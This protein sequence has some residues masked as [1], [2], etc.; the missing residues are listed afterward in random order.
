MEHKLLIWMMRNSTEK[1]HSLAFIVITLLVATVL[2]GALRV[3]VT[4]QTEIHKPVRADAREYLTYAYN[5]KHHGIYSRTFAEADSPPDAVRSPGYPIFLLPFTNG[6]PT[7]KSVKQITYTQAIIGA[8]VVSLSLMVFLKMMTPSFAIIAT[9]LTVA[10]PHLIS[11]GTY[12]L[13]ETLFSILCIA[14]VAL[15]VLSLERQSTTLMLGIGVLLGLSTL[16]RPSLQYFVFAYLVFFIFH[17]GFRSGVKKTVLVT[18]AFLIIYSPW[19]IRNQISTGSISDARLTTNFLHHG[20]YPDFKFQDDPQSFGF[21]YRA[22]PRSDEIGK[23]THS[24]LNEIIARFKNEPQ[25]H[26]IWFLF[27]KPL[28]LWGWDTINGAGDV[29]VYPPVSS[30]YLSETPHKA[31]HGFMKAIHPVVISL[32]LLAAFVVWLPRKMLGVPAGSLY[33]AR[34]MSIFTLYFLALHVVGA[35]FP[36]YSVPLRPMSYGLFAYFLYLSYN[37]YEIRKAD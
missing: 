36:R 25:R 29:F 26:L 37:Y 24:A 7:V 22:D 19:L 6:M 31:V 23:D 14:L 34:F 15:S 30:P 16:M 21:P 32:G 27:K 1:S 11:A 8:F 28:A 17:F 9:A 5:M 35:P 2:A 33:A 12:V 3:S 20:M 13:T 18:V 10:S 4:N